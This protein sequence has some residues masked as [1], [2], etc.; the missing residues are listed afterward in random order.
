MFFALCLTIVGFGMA[1]AYENTIAITEKNENSE[2]AGYGN[3]YGIQWEKSYGSSPSYGA[4]YEGPQSIGDCDN[5]GKNDG[6]NDTNNSTNYR[7]Q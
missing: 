3:G 5:D 6:K 7:C 4:R 1:S 2:L